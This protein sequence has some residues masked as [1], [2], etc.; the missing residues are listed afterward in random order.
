MSDC[1]ST[2]SI[3]IFT[4]FEPD[5]KTQILL[6]FLPHSNLLNGHLE[7][8]LF[9]FCALLIG[10]SKTGIQGIGALTVPLLAILFGAKSS[11]GIL[12]PILCFADLIAIIYYRR[13]F[14]LKYILPLLPW[15]ITGLLIA[16]LVDHGIPPSQ[17]RRLMAFCIFLGL[18][19]LFWS[20]RKGKTEDITGR[21][22][23]SP[24]FGTVMGFATMIGNAAGPIMSVYLLSTKLPKYV[25]ISTG[26]WFVM[27]VNLIKVPL[28]VFV[29]DNINMEVL[30]LDLTTVPFLLIGAW[31]G[32]KLVKVLPE[33]K[34]RAV[35]IAL[36]IVATAMLLY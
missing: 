12:L 32:V 26:A 33:A 29:W 30:M 9:F 5:L 10:M 22:W 14:K 3:N 2:H 35:T 36:T 15:S 13:D 1:P 28:Q 16:L 18:A 24:L 8:A 23:Y 11:T 34:F 4:T 25:F 31:M 20:E 21:A 27:I 17:F 6:N 7:W 19:V